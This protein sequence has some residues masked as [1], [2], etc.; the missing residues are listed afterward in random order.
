MP[1]QPEFTFRLPTGEEVQGYLVRLADGSTVIR[2]AQELEQLAP[3]ERRLARRPVAPFG[4]DAD[5]GET[6]G[7]GA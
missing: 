5:E 2:T 3:L 7:G 6:G 1:D 4:V